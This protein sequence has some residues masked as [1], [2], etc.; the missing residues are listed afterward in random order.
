[1]ENYSICVIEDNIP[2]RKLYVTLLKKAG[3]VTYDFGDG[4]SSLNWLKTNNV[5]GIIMDILLPDIN[6]NDLVKQVKSLENHKKTI[7]CA[8]TGFA[9]D[10]DKEK[11]LNDGFSHYLSK[12]INTATFIDDIKTMF[13]LK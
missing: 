6:G 10:Q 2:I 8:I 4:G 9:Q 13:N 3:F 1:M 7:V 11:F 5:N 12:P